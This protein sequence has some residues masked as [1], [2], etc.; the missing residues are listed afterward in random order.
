MCVRGAAQTYLKH[1]VDVV[2]LGL[3]QLAPRGEV[4]VGEDAA[5]LQEPVGVTLR[6]SGRQQ[7]PSVDPRAQCYHPGCHPELLADCLSIYCLHSNHFE[8][9]R[10]EPHEKF[11]KKIQEKQGLGAVV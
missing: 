6:D 8:A 11:M 1:L 9:A 10:V 2:V 3:E 4:A 7:L 5:G